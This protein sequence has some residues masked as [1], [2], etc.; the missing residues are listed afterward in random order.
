MSF[1]LIF[2]FVEFLLLLNL[3]VY[4]Y[5]FNY[6]V[7]IFSSWYFEK[8]FMIGTLLE[9]FFVELEGKNVITQTALVLFF[10]NL[11]HISDYVIHGGILGIGM[12]MEQRTVKLW[13]CTV[14]YATRRLAIGGWDIWVWIC[15]QSMVCLTYLKFG[16][17]LG[18]VLHN[19]TDFDS[20]SKGCLALRLW[21]CWDYGLTLLFSFILPYQLINDV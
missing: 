1:C 18:W 17:S 21:H 12:V 4:L 19:L 20:S 3:D 8:V 9:I 11:L 16:S 2:F 15:A 7:V 13:A 6:S 14:F 5:F 10:L